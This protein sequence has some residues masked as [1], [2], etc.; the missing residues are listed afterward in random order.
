MSRKHIKLGFT[1]SDI[2]DHGLRNGRYNPRVRIARELG[3][4][5]TYRTEAAAGSS[6][7]VGIT[8]R[9]PATCKLWAREHINKARE[10]RR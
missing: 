4:A 5:A 10:A 6:F 7:T 8:G 1:H 9:T 2:V 3:T